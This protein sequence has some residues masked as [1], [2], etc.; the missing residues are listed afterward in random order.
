MGIVRTHECSPWNHE[1]VEV[2]ANGTHVVLYNGVGD[3]REDLREMLCR[4]KEH[5]LQGWFSR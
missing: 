3:I 5:S 4:S 2:R 1:A